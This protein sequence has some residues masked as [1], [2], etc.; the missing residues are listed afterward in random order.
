MMPVLGKYA[1]PVIGSYAVTLVLL[2]AVVIYALWRG[3]RV[4]RALA[5]AEARIG[6]GGG[7]SHE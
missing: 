4:R 1:V 5:A 2:A 6:M 3:A 7:A